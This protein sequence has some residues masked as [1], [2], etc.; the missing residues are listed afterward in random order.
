MGGPFAPSWRALSP[1]VRLNIL[2]SAASSLASSIVSSSVFLSPYVFYLEGAAN[3]AVDVGL[4][5]A[6]AG[7]TQLALAVPVG[8]V[9]DRVPRH[10]VLRASGVAGLAS[11]AVL[12]VALALDSMPVL[13][14]ASALAGVYAAL[15][16]PPLASI[17]A[18]SIPSGQRTALYAVQYAVSLAAGAAGPAIGAGFFVWLG[19]EWRTPQLR[20]VMLAGNVLNAASCLLLFFFHDDHSLG[21]ESDGV[22]AEGGGG[23]AGSSGWC[24]GKRGTDAA[25]GDEPGDGGGA[26]PLLAA[27]EGGGEPAAGDGGAGAAGGEKSSSSSSSSSS[28]TRNLGHQTLRLGCGTLSVRHIPYLIFA[29]DFTIALGAGMTVQYFSLFFSVEYTLSPAVTAAIWVA[30]P[31]LIAA[32]STGA[33]PV[34]RRVGRAG[35]AV[36]CDAIGTAC[37]FALSIRGAPVGVAVPVYLL[38][39]AAMNASYPVQRAILMDVVP[40]K[41][42]GVWNSAES[43]TSFTWTGSAAIGGVLVDRFGYGFTFV[44]TGAL[45]VVATAILAALIPLTWGEI[46]DTTDTAT[47]AGAGEGE[48]AGADDDRTGVGANA[49]GGGGGGDG[50]GGGGGVC[51]PSSDVGAGEAGDARGSAGADAAR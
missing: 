19:D 42:R 5:S 13:Y 7:L 6:A 43:L 48:G 31:L 30:S 20:A 14:A 17:F 39:T 9:T 32:M 35:V 25:G 27:E 8:V 40:K 36:L 44:V 34:A 33:V 18:D 12:F 16:G 28:S 46:T 11:S 3:S 1:N 15:V 47:G 41:R 22:L 29:S 26:E 51:S 10:V 21:E 45:Y 38:R 23:A 50:G 37:L 24:R 4:V 49:G 2:Y